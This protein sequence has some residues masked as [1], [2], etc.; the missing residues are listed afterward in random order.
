MRGLRETPLDD[1]LL[2][3]LLLPVHWLTDLCQVDL[4]K[5]LTLSVRLAAK[6]MPQLKS[7]V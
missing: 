1:K 5:T 4:A 3:S 7:A 2:S 6:P